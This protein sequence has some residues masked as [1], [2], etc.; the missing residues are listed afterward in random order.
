MSENLGNLVRGMFEAPPGFTFWAR[1]FKGIEAVLVGYFARS[2]RYIRLAKLGVHDYFT[3]Y[4]LAEQ[5]I[6]PHSCVPDLNLTDSDLALA[7][8]F[9]KKDFKPARE[10]GKRC[11]HLSNYRGTPYRMHKEY[12]ETFPSTKAAAQVQG[13]YYELFW[14]IPSWHA[15]MCLTVD[16]SMSPEQAWVPLAGSCGSGFITT[17]FGVTNTFW[18]VIEHKHD[19]FG[20]PMWDFGED[21]KRLIAAL[22]QS[23][24]SSIMK[25]A[26]LAI[27]VLPATLETALAVPDFTSRYAVPYSPIAKSLR[28]SI[29][30]ELLGMCEATDAQ[31]YL[32]VAKII[33]EREW[34][35]L[36]LDPAWNMNE[37]CL[38]IG[39]EGKLGPVWG[40]MKEAH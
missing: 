3:A 12:P 38:S 11:V 15:E 7:L 24:A 26:M 2:A 9:I 16:G 10:I 5:K 28:L 30:D 14:E 21:A 35:Q 33:M 40:E 32:T 13:M 17:P 4:M 22:P 37:K 31:H 20:D 29:H 1:D 25:M 8:K 27:W 34:S 36:P 23:T 19:K 18:D 39:T 6:I